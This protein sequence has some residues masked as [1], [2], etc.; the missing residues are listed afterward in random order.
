MMKVPKNYDNLSKRELMKTIIKQKN[1]ITDLEE[2]LNVSAPVASFT[3]PI[4]DKVQTSNNVSKSEHYVNPDLCRFLKSENEICDTPEHGCKC[5]GCMSYFETESKRRRDITNMCNSYKKACDEKIY[6][7]EKELTEEESEVSD[8][9][10]KICDTPQY[11]C[12][13]KGCVSYFTTV[14][15][16]KIYAASTM[17]GDLNPNWVGIREYWKPSVSKDQE[18]EAK[19]EEKPE[20]TKKN[21]KKTMKKKN[22][23]TKSK[24]K[25]QLGNDSKLQ[26]VFNIDLSCKNLDD[27]DDSESSDSEKETLDVNDAISKK[28]DEAFNKKMSD[29][30]YIIE[31]KLDHDNYM[32]EILLSELNQEIN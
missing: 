21:T 2:K 5:E 9:Q 22:K 27:S 15:D 29:I 32:H 11:G 13:C 10:Y 3:P 12:K 23:V 16:K 17:S 26:F 4:L 19:V 1:K 28:I 25:M 14:R 7:K 30:T 31:Q 24:K 8:K 6:N 18:K 20:E